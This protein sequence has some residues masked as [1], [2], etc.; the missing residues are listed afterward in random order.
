M[1]SPALQRSAPK[2]L[3]HLAGRADGFSR[4][5]PRQHRRVERPAHRPRLHR[6]G[7]RSLYP[8]TPGCAQAPP[9][10]NPDGVPSPWPCEESAHDRAHPRLPAPQPRDDGPCLVRRPRRRARQL[11]GLR[12]G[13]AGHARVLCREGQSGAGGA[14]AA[15]LA[16]A[17]A[18]IPL[19]CRDRAGARGRRHARTASASATRSRRSA[20]SRAPTRLA[21]ASLR[22][23]ARPRSRRS[24]APRPARKVFCRM[25]CDGAGAEWPLSRKF[26]CAPAMAAACSSTRIGSASC[27]MACRSMSARSS[28]TRM[29]GSRAGLG[30]GRVPR[31]RRARHPRSRWSISAAASRR[32][33]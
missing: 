33:I 9:E 16:S 14:V 8:L 13:A 26:G 3:V 11:P 19:R 15:R 25:L 5:N 12:Q 21:C 29:L 23:I 1:V 28:A 20:T 2:R 32:T 24:R 17:R 4:S 27:R 18:S 22:S 30:G 7:V 31:L 6:A 10:R